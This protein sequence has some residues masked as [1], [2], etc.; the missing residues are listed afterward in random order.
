MRSCLVHQTL[1]ILFSVVGSY[2][3]II[4]MQIEGTL[5]PRCELHVKGV[6]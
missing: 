1:I 3:I 4:F 5:L 2:H 6:V